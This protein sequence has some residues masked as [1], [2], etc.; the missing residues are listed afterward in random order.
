MAEIQRLG[1]TPI[2]DLMHFGVPDFI[3]NFQNPELPVHFAA[4][5]EEVA[6]RYPVGALLHAG[7]RDLRHG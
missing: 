3:G 2:L 7:K 4:Y 1:I 5:C 6:K